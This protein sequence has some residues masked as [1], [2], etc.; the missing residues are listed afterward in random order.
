[1]K[2][3]LKSSNG[4]LDREFLVEFPWLGKVGRWS[5]VG[6]DIFE[7]KDPVKEKKDIGD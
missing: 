2:T 4:N 7:E 5:C 6:D 1:L 3:D